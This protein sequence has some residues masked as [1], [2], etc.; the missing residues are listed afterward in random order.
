MLTMQFRNMV[1]QMGYSPQNQN[2]YNVLGNNNDTTA[3]ET[4]T[5]N[6]A[7]LTTGS[8]ITGS[9][10]A[11]STHNLVIQAINQLRANQTTLINQMA[12]MS[13]T[14]ANNAPPQQYTVPLPIQQVNIPAQA[15]YP[16]TSSGRFNVG[17][18]GRGKTAKGHRTS[19][20]SG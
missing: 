13:F 2:M 4:T 3:A 17:R 5:T 15:P 18:G 9:H 8:T 19:Q 11:A 16:G 14:N 12:V 6:I 10:T 1:G 20:G 7:A